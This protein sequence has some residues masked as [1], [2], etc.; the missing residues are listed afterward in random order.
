LR[1]LGYRVTG[2]DQ[3]PDGVTLAR[4][5]YPDIR[6]EV[7]SIYE[8]IG[9]RLGETD[10]DLVVSSEVIEHLYFPRKLLQN[11][12]LVLR[13]GGTIIV[14]TPYHGYLKNLALSLF[15]K[16]DDHH[17]VHW[18]GG[19][20]KFF[21]ERTLTAFLEE[22]GFTEIRFSNAGRASWLWKS[23]VCRALRPAD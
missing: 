21:S 4:K 9:Q 10:F 15:N 8:D 11:A 23:M 6:F 14:T 5:A 2:V 20:I 18:D 16:W 22:A 13:P 19:H 12:R 7:A 1:A 17:T 3:S